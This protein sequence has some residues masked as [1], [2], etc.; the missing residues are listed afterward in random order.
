MKRLML[1]LALLSSAAWPAVAADLHFLPPP[2]MVEK[3]LNEHPI[4][5]Q[6]EAQLDAAKADAD[7]LRAGPH[8]F[9]LSGYA[10]NRTVNHQG[11]F[12]VWDLTLS[13]GIRIGGKAALDAQAGSLGVEFGNNAIEDA[14]HQTALLLMYDWMAWLEAD[15]L[16]KINDDEAQSYARE[17]DAVA[18]RVL[19][20][21]A[22]RRD[23]DL[24]NAAFA[25]ASAA[26]LASRGAVAEAQAALQRIFPEMPLMPVVPE[27]APP[28]LPELPLDRW[29]NL[30]LQRSHEVRLAE[31]EAAKQQTL[32]SRA[33]ADRLPDPSLGL[34]AY[35]DNAGVE[36][37]LA[38][39]FSIPIGGSGRPAA[40]NAQAAKA[41]AAVS[42]LARVKRE[43]EM[44]AQQD[45][46]KARTGVVAWQQAA[47]AREA[48]AAAMTR[49][50]RGYDL[51]EFDL[52]EQ[53]LIARQYYDA[54][55]VELTARATAQRATLQLQIDGHELWVLED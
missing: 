38:L 27:I 12:G 14:K 26:A 45:V 3:I 11:D 1:V 6:A 50:R 42:D 5:G 39:V 13:R 35:S 2:E 48:A 31:L 10:G 7:R 44:R 19:R 18:Q 52:S 33:Y 21:D 25:R 54:Q 29:F 51:G 28:E 46:L 55:R 53:L 17:R 30:I 16:A 23:A 8:E 37:A 43:Y 22:A 40:A 4:V 32:A 36:T 20:Q 49:T 41:R 47:A 24:A 15:G 9:Q 34:R